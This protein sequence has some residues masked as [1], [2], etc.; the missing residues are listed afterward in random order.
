[1]RRLLI[2]C[3]L[4]INVLCA[5]E[6]NAQHIFPFSEGERV[7]Y[8]AI[9]QMPNAYISGICILLNEDGVI[10]GCLFNEFGITALDFTF[11]PKL[12]KVE[13]HHIVEIMDKWYI[14][15]VLRKDLVRLMS[16]LQRGE[17]TYYNEHRNIT[18]QFVPIANEIVQ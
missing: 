4:F 13:L 15:R 18:Y 8:T 9:I 14:R 2:A 7:R 10:K 12:R 3:L 5:T 1:M 16:S 17:S 6:L 11:N